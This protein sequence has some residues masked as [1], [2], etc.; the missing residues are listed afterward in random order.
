MTPDVD[1][2]W[3]RRFDA[4]ARRLATKERA[5]AFLGGRCQICG[6]DGCPAAFDF[7]HPDPQSKDFTISSRTVW[8]A[9]LERELRKTVLLCANCHREVH[10]GWYPSYVDSDED[11]RGG[12]L[13]ESD[14][15][16][17]PQSG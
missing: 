17:P 13:Y 9:A 12:S 15:W 16:E 5:I 11:E 10:A 3:Q 6:Y 4:A 8:S 2:R 1:Q 14:D 7:H